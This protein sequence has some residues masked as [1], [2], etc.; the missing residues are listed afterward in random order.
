MFA[1]GHASRISPRIWKLLLENNIYLFIIPSHTSHLLQVLDLLPNAVVK[2]NLLKIKKIPKKTCSSEELIQFVKEV[3]EVVS[4]SLT[5]EVIRRAVVQCPLFFQNSELVYE[6][7]EK[8]ISNFKKSSDNPIHHR[9]KFPVSGK[10]VTE[11]KFI[12]DV[13]KEKEKIKKKQKNFPIDGKEQLQQ[14][15]VSGEK[16]EEITIDIE[17]ENDTTDSNGIDEIITEE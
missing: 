4:K 5:K 11:L 17:E 13:E 15:A 12:D 9:G 1:D 16:E 6:V 8:F 3:E 10:L 14:I 7:D 2:T